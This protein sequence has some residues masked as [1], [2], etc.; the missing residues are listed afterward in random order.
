MLH[1]FPQQHKHTASER[2][3]ELN[4]SLP[5][6]RKTYST[7]L[8]VQLLYLNGKLPWSP[9]HCRIEANRAD[10]SEHEEENARDPKREEWESWF[11]SMLLISQ[12]N[13]NESHVKSQFSE[14]DV[15]DLC[16]H[17]EH[18]QSNLWARDSSSTE[19]VSLDCILIRRP[20]FS[21]SYRYS[22]HALVVSWAQ[23][24]MSILSWET[25]AFSKIVSHI[26]CVKNLMLVSSLIITPNSVSENAM[27]YHCTQ[28][29]KI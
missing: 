18:S 9:N 29:Q 14:I 4:S 8:I 10:F 6:E 26:K 12:L 15:Q 28:G 5:A 13:R 21:C 3:H 27:S 23:P 7:K 17:F 11:G 24:S 2:S 1:K 20:D 25:P 16:P 22:F 19:Q